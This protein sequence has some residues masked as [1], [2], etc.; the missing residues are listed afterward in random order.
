MPSKRARGSY[1]KLICLH[2]R[3]RKIKCNLPDEATIQPSNTP[4]PPGKK[5]ERCRQRALDC[6]VDHTTLG[7]PAYKRSRVEVILTADS[8][9]DFPQPTGEASSADVERFLLSTPPQGDVPGCQTQKPSNSEMVDALSNQFR[10]LRSLVSRD[11]G[12]ANILPGYSPTPM[13]KSILELVN[14]ALSGL[15]DRQ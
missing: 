14:P 5:C 1:A 7:R 12:F 10:H 6:I 2:C 9:D 11:K 8:L 15:L 13:R 3:S 4:Q